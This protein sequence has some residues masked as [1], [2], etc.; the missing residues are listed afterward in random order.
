[1]TGDGDVKVFTVLAVV[2]LAALVTY[3]V[4]MVVH[5]LWNVVT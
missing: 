1:M 5:V 4:G 2:F 3:A